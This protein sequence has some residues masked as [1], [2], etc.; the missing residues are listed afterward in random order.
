MSKLCNS[1]GYTKEFLE[2]TR[3]SNSPDGYYSLCKQC[4]RDRQYKATYGISLEEYQTLLELQE[5]CC[6]ICGDHAS[7]VA[8]NRLYVDH[9]HKEGHVRG[10]LCSHCNFVLGQAKDNVEILESAILYL[11]ERG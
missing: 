2:F 7:T 9:C 1:C 4:K 8:K 3:N 6:A 5:E 11:K 10:L